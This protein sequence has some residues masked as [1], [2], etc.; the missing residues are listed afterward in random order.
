MMIWHHQWS[1]KHFCNLTILKFCLQGG[2]NVEAFRQE[3]GARISISKAQASAPE[4]IITITGGQT[5]I[6]KACELITEKINKVG[7]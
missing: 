4:R 5:Q 7:E 6:R 1:N 3:S 2:S